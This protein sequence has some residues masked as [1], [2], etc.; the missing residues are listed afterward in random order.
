[1]VTEERTFDKY[2]NDSASEIQHG[3]PATISSNTSSSTPSY[4]NHVTINNSEVIAENTNVDR[5]TFAA[6][7]FSAG[8][9][10]PS[11][12]PI[13]DF[14]SVLLEMDIDLKSV[15]VINKLS[16][17]VALPAE[18]IRLYIT[19]SIA[20]CENIKDKY[21]QVRPTCFL[22]SQNNLRGIMSSDKY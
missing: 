12:S 5:E 6:T 19:N 16:M 21:L 10:N 13:S 17:S 20:A 7:E 9:V 22:F 15:E 11:P 18:F 2:E 8:N 1:M 3:P 14:L 4:D